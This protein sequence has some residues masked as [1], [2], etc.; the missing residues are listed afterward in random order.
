MTTKDCQNTSFALLR[1]AED[2]DL[3]MTL[4]VM[5]EGSEVSASIIAKLDSAL[6]AETV[7]SASS[8][9]PRS[10]MTTPFM[11]ASGSECEKFPTSVARVMTDVLLAT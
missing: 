9:N 8:R 5:P 10:R 2:A 7:S 11:S 1:E 6:Q 3:K 4:Q